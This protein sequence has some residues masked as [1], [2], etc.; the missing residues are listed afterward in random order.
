M[1]NAEESGRWPMEWKGA[2]FH[3]FHGDFH[4]ENGKYGSLRYR[5]CRRGGTPW[6]DIMRGSVWNWVCGMRYQQPHNKNL[7]NNTNSTP[8]HQQQAHQPHTPGTPT[9]TRPTTPTRPIPTST[10]PTTPTINAT[11]LPYPSPITHTP[12]THTTRATYHHTYTT[13]LH[14][15]CTPHPRHTPTGS[16]TRHNQPDRPRATL[17]S[18]ERH[19]P[20]AGLG[21]LGGSNRL[22]VVLVGGLWAA[23]Y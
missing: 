15:L 18:W 14:T 7:N 5:L 8:Q 22:L 3:D 4:V 17:G 11:L 12:I 6:R 10:T 20:R 2:D 21:W 13:F 1:W 19:R 16:P 23:A 9:T